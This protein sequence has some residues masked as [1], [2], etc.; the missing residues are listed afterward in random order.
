MRAAVEIGGFT[1]SESDDL[2]K[3][4]SKKMADKIAKKQEKFIKGAVE[5]GVM[6]KT[7]ATAIFEDWEQFARYGFNKPLTVTRRRLRPGRRAAGYR[8]T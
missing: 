4:I 5:K 6:D 1:R 2:R 7:T 8:L 3:A